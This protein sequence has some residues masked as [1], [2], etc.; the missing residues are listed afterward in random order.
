M[1]DAEKQPKEKQLRLSESSLPLLR[2]SVIDVICLFLRF[3]DLAVFLEFGHCEA[4]EEVLELLYV[5]RS[6]HQYVLGVDDDAVPDSSHGKQLIGSVGIDDV[7]VAFLD[8]ELRLHADSVAV[9]VVMGEVV[10]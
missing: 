9:G 7:P 4:G 10:V 6:Y 2:V 5:A 1:N 3:V 8:K